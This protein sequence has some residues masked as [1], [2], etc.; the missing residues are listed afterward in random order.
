MDTTYAVNVFAFGSPLRQA[1]DVASTALRSRDTLSFMVCGFSALSTGKPHTEDWQAPYCRRLESDRILAF[2][3]D[4]NRS[5][6]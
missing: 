3:E 5:K 2:Y 4:L 1:Q 6:S